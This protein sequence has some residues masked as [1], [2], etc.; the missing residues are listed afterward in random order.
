MRLSFHRGDGVKWN[1]CRRPDTRCVRVSPLREFFRALVGVFQ[2]RT[3]FLRARRDTTLPQRDVP[4][5]LP[6]M[7]R[8]WRAHRAHIDRTMMR[9]RRGLV[10]YPALLWQ[11]TRNES[12]AGSISKQGKR[13][14][15]AASYWPHRRFA[16]SPGVA[17]A[18]ADFTLTLAKKTPRLPGVIYRGMIRWSS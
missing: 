3:A 13:F 1:H 11:A 6:L 2:G 16:I 15:P 18:R 5:I 8:P 9:F 10:A 14:A 4:S 17:I 12:V 7:S